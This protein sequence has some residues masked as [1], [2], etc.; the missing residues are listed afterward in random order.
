MANH[1]ELQVTS[2]RFDESEPCWSPDGETIAFVSNRTQDPD[3]NYN[4][5]IWI[6]SAS[7]TDKGQTLRQLTTNSGPDRSPKWSP[8]GKWIAYITASDAVYATEHLA[9]VPAAGGPPR[10]LTKDLD[11]NVSPFAFSSDSHSIYFLFE[12]RGEVTSGRSRSTVV[13]SNA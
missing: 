13:R 6:V 9:I 5:D 10:I 4:T 2:G 3:R 7:N 12:M 1:S 11:R 8:D